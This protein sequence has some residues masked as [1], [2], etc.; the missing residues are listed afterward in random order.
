[1]DTAPAMTVEP[2]PPVDPFANLP[3][4]C[5]NP[6]SMFGNEDNCGGLVCHGSASG[7]GAYVDLGYDSIGLVDRL[8]D[9]PGIATCETFK[10]IDSADPSNSLLILKLED[11]AICGEAMPYSG[12]TI[13]PEQRECIIAWT[14]AAAASAAP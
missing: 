7:A 12:R 10:L 3:A 8:M 14:L 6:P 1:M 9:A 11:P 4:G 13:T 2:P 5:S